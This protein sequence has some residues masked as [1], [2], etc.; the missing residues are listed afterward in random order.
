MAIN[1]SPLAPVDIERPE[2]W[3]I[4]DRCA[5]RWLRR[6]LQWQVDWRGLQ[7]Q[8][9]WLLVCVDCYDVPQEQF[10]P[11]IIGPDP[12]P[13]KDPRPGWYYS[14]MGPTPIFS[15]EEILGDVPGQQAAIVDNLANPNM[16]NTNPLQPPK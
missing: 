11:I 15:V 12:V 10:R 8:N 2:P 7:L 3:G 9:L 4:C 1:H 16:G 14:Q 13:V 5:R 6:D